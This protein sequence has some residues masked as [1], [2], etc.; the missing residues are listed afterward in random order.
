VRVREEGER[1]LRKEGASST[2]FASKSK[3]EKQIKRHEGRNNKKRRMTIMM[4]IA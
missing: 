1:T 4:M 3:A 2:N